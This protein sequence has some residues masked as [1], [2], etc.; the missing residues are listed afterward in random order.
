VYDLVPP[1]SLNGPGDVILGVIGME[2]P[3]T[4]YWPASLDQTVSQQRSWA[5]WWNSSPPP[6]PPL[7]PPDEWTPIDTYFP[8]NWMVRGYGAVCRAPGCEPP[9]I[10]WITVDPTAG[11]TPGHSTFSVDVTFDSTG[12]APGTYTATLSVESNDPDEPVVLVPLTMTVLAPPNIEVTPLS[13]SQEL[14]P[15]ATATQQLTICNSGDLP[16]DWELIELPCQGEAL[17]PPSRVPASVEGAAP[18]TAAAPARPL[19][20]AEPAASP[21]WPLWD[22]P[23]SEVN[24]DSY[25]DQEFPDF[26][27]YSSFLADDFYGDD[28]FWITAIFVPGDGWN[29]FSS[30]LNADSLTWQIYADNGGVPD[31]DPAGGG[32]PPVW[33][34]TLPPADPQVVIGAGTPGGYPSDTTLNLV[35]PITVPPGHWWLVFYPTLSFGS[36]GQFGRQPS[37]TTNGYGAQFINPGGGFGFGTVWT[38]AS[39]IGFP[40]SDLAFRLDGGCCIPP[41]IPWLSEDPLAGTVAPHTCQ[42][43]DV[44]FDSTEIQPGDYY[45]DLLITSDDPD[46]PEVTVPVSLTVLAPI[47]GVDWTWSPLAPLAG[48]TVSFSATVAAGTPPFTFDWEWGDGTTGSGQYPTHTYSVPGDH[49]VV[50]TAGGACGEGLAQRTVTVEPRYVYLYLPVVLKSHAP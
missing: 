35:L 15:D 32:N 42:A 28:Y 13:L 25:V 16:L 22:Q 4:S 11:S 49:L 31:G 8:G 18:I 47:S 29:G 20:K 40:G 37:D 50:L 30:L 1:V 9:D 36:G 5:G 6:S 34:L 23:L 7:L 39:E 38:A 2:V 45:G 19:G 21:E 43:V 48:E 41:I 24:Q 44:T 26:P 12:M 17:S 14:C 3:G 33:T 10:L 46:T 27:D